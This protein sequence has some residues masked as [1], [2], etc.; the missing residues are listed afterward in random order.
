MYWLTRKMFHEKKKEK[1][2]RIYSNIYLVAHVINHGG[3]SYDEPFAYLIILSVHVYARLSCS[4]FPR[5]NKI[6]NI[7][8]TCCHWLFHRLWRKYKSIIWPATI[9]PERFLRLSAVHLVNWKCWNW[10]SSSTYFNT[11]TLPVILLVS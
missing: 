2:K 1:K 7:Y 10:A 8:L 4:F 5:A 6:P 3:V 9:W 11:R